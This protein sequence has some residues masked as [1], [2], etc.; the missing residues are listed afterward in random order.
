MNRMNR[1]IVRNLNTEF[2]FKIQQHSLVLKLMS[3]GVCLYVSHHFLQENTWKWG[4]KIIG[5]TFFTGFQLDL[6]E[7]KVYMILNIKRFHFRKND[8]SDSFV[9]DFPGDVNTFLVSN[10]ISFFIWFFKLFK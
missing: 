5:V 8:V 4:L 1:Y 7:N 10:K 3:R 6:L 2:L 9:I